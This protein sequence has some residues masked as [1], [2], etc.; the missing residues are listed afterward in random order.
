MPMDETPGMPIKYELTA[1]SV[2]W[3]S[4]MVAVDE[5]DEDDVVGVVVDDVELLEFA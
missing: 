3:T 4:A 1:C 5:L 2:D